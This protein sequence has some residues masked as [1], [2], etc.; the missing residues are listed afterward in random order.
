MEERFKDLSQK[1]EIENFV[2]LIKREA[3]THVVIT[4]F[5]V[6]SHVYCTFLLI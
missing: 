3:E 6:K 5:D 2:T 1:Y 4:F